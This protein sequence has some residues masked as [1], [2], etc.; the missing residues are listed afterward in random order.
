MRYSPQECEF[1]YAYI[2]CA[3]LCGYDACVHCSFC[4]QTNLLP[5]PPAKKVMMY[6]NTQ[7]A[8]NNIHVLII[9]TF[10]AEIICLM[11]TELLCPCMNS[12]VI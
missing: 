6:T 2:V 10:T 4:L 1:A 12:G 9:T 11:F 5:T 3:C 8:A 7:Q